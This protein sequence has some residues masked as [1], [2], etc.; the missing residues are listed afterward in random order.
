MPLDVNGQMI[1]ASTSLPKA[2]ATVTVT[3]EARSLPASSRLKAAYSTASNS[4][5]QIVGSSSLGP[6]AVGTGTLKSFPKQLDIR[7][8]P[9]VPPGQTVKIEALV[10]EVDASSHPIGAPRPASCFLSVQSAGMMAVTTSPNISQNLRTFRAAAG[11]SQ[12]A[13]ARQLRV[14]RSTISR[15]ERGQKPSDRMAAEIQGVI[16][17]H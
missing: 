11:L 4:T 9:G 7:P 6:V 12:A 10:Q 13:V 17:R 2:G 14:S 3:F 1:P 8:K 16:D 5:F 15:I